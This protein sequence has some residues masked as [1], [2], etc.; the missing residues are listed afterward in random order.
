M[1]AMTADHL[2]NSFAGESQA[3]M[4]YLVYSD[5]AEKAGFP[6]IAR[7]FRAV[8]YAEQVHAISD[9]QL[10][11]RGKLGSTADNLEAA[12]GGEEFEVAEMYAVYKAAAE[13]Q[14]EKGAARSFDWALQAE[15]T[16]A[17]MFKKAKA[18]VEA[19]ED[20]E[21]GP[22]YICSLCGHAFQGEAPDRCPVCN[23]PRDK[24]RK[25]D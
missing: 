22:V 14:E 21:V 5:K 4:R 1:R 2:R 8:A 11:E 18:A 10:L 24:F 12:I 15:K 17:T 16:H 7:L 19:G 6:N 23:A 9:F 3:H 25:F 20:Y 13:F